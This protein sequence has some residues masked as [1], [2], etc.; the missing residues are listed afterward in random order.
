[1]VY[2][3]CPC[4]VEREEYCSHHMLKLEILRLFAALLLDKSDDTRWSRSSSSPSGVLAKCSS[5][6]VEAL[7]LVLAE[8]RAVAQNVFEQLLSGSSG[9]RS[10]SILVSMADP[11]YTLATGL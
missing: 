6:L 9:P 8:A 11:S 1:M 4:C 3:P 5:K 10:V 2:P 7:Q